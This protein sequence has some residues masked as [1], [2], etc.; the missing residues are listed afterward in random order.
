MRTSFFI[1][2]FLFISASASAQVAFGC[3]TLDFETVPGSEPASGVVLSDQYKET[4]GVTFSLEGGGHPVLAEVGGD[5]G[6]AE[7]FVSNWGTDTPAPGIDIGRF[8]LTDDGVLAGLESPPIILTFD[9]PID[10]FAGCILDM[11]F[12]EIFRIEAAD[13]D[14]NIVLEETIVAGD[15]GTGDGAL[16]CWGFNLPGCEGVISTIKYSGSRTTAGGF[17]LGMDGFSFCYTAAPLEAIIIP[18]SCTALGSVEILETAGYTFSFDGGPFTDQ[19]FWDNL[20]SGSYAIKVRDEDGCETEIPAFVVEL[21]E[22]EIEAVDF[23]NTSCG[24]DNGTITVDAGETQGPTYSLDGIEFQESNIFENLPPEIYTVFVQ[25]S[26]GCVSINGA[27]IEPSIAPEVTLLTVS[28]DKCRSGVGVITVDALGENLSYSLDGGVNFQAENRFDGLSEGSYEVLVIDANGCTTAMETSLETTENVILQD[29]LP[30]PAVCN[31]NNGFI[32]VAAEGGEGDFTFSLDG[33]TPQTENVFQDLLSG[34]YTVIVTDENGCTAEGQA[35]ID[36]PDI[37]EIEA[38]DPLDTRCNEANGSLT[39]TSTLPNITEYSLDGENFTSGNVFADLPAGDYDIFIIDENG[40][41]NQT[42]AT[43]APSTALLVETS[44]ATVDSCEASKGTIRVIGT[45][46]N[47]PI[48]Y[49]LDNATPVAEGFFQNLVGGPY[50]VA[51]T[52]ALG[53]NIDVD[54]NVPTTPAVL[55]TG[56]D[57]TPPECYE[58]DGKVEIVTRGGEGGLV[59]ILLDSIAQPLGFENLAPGGY[60]IEVTD[61]LGCVGTREIEVPFPYC[62]IYIPNVIAL[63]EIRPEDVFRI[64]THPRYQACVMDYRIYSRWGELVYRAENFDIHDRD[65]HFWDGRFNGKKAEQDAYT[66]LIEIKHPN[67]LHERFAGSVMLIR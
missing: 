46:E 14:G 36:R 26:F 13:I 40:C 37:A 38:V 27:I 25:D 56:V 9:V 50:N 47:M 48:S 22:T 67:G 30:S 61:E 66:Y 54:M 23:E 15:P 33:G 21:A 55:I 45:S 28:N 4:F 20:I 32:E 39:I 63:Q 12:G 34:T 52:D 29:L 44:V 1:L 62:P 11:D 53:C 31:G 7:A 19:V 49:S 18:E 3:L 35:T 41:R 42:Q 51:L 8:F 2:I 60:V 64:S 10:T 17:G 43:I 65:K 59:S 24:E 6:S 58:D 16:T 5:S 57:V